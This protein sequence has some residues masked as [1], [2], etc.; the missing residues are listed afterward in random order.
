MKKN[1]LRFIILLIISP[2]SGFSSSDNPRSELTRY[3]L[4]R[5]KFILDRRMKHDDFDAYLFADGNISSGLKSIIGDAK[6]ADGSNSEI[7]S[8]LNRNVNTEK[9]IDI[10][11]S[12]GVPLPYFTLGGY[13]FLPNLFFSTNIGV[14]LSF[15][16]KNDILN[17]K[18]QIYFKNDI[19]MG[20]RSLIKL[21]DRKTLDLAIYQLQRTDLFTEKTAT[22]I[23]TQG[24]LFEL[25]ELGEKE[26]AINIDLSYRI[27]SERSE[28]LYELQEVR[29]IPMGNSNNKSDYKNLP[30]F[31]FGG[32]RFYWIND[33]KWTLLGGLHFRN[34]Y[35]PLE[36]LYIGGNWLHH[37]NSPFSVTTKI[38]SEFITLL[39]QFETSWLKFSYMLK[40]P[41]INPK[42]N[43][44]VSTMHSLTLILPF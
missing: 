16:N 12:L 15:F 17:P 42:D 2:V 18:L 21:N 35:S 23:S 40:L 10:D 9:Y 13:K 33:T 30:M 44:W 5:D 6:N 27:K 7:I 8:L 37:K 20:V 26:Q 36:G 1:F 14:S 22:E 25:D 24:K 41:Y 38:S 29:L 19:K 31:H 43:L 11:F 32:K 28:Q 34:R 3:Y 39:P 4:L